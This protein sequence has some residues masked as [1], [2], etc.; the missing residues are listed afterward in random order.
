LAHFEEW[1]LIARTVAFGIDMGTAVAEHFRLLFAMPPEQIKLVM[2]RMARALA[3][4]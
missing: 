4:V 1:E 2:E 3:T